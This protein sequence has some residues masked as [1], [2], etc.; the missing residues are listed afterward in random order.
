VTKNP[1]KKILGFSTHTDLMGVG[2]LFLWSIKQGIRPSRQLDNCEGKGKIDAK[3]FDD[4][5]KGEKT[6]VSEKETF[7]VII[8]QLIA[9]VFDFLLRFFYVFT[10]FCN[11]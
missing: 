8:N 11:L 7:V 3:S 10:M 2:R 4:I 5:T 1:R 9:S 6:K